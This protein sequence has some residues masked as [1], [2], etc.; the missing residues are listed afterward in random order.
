MHDILIGAP[1]DILASAR[2][3]LLQRSDEDFIQSTLDELRSPQGRQALAGRRAKAVNAQGTLKLFQPIQR[4]FHLALVEAWC[5]TPGA[6]RIDPQRV[7]SAGL[8]VRRLDAGG[9]PQGWMRSNGRVRGWV[10]ISRVG[11]SASDPA[12]RHRLQRRLTGVA[13]IDRQLSGFALRQPDNLFEE[14]VVPLFI[15][16]PDVCAE[17]GKTVFY[18]M[19]PT[20]SSEISEAAPAASAAGSVDFG[21]NSSAFRTHLAAPLRGLATPFPFAGAQVVPGWFDASEAPGEVRPADVSAAQFAALKAPIENS[22]Q[23]SQPAG[24]MRVFLLLL[25]QLASEFNAFDG[26]AEANALRTALAAIRLPLV[27]KQGQ[28]E[29]DTVRADLFLADACKLLLKKESI[30]APLEMPERWP[31]LSPELTQGLANAMHSAMQARAAALL[32]Q[33]CRYDE[34]GARYQ[35]RAFVRIK[36]EGAC[37]TRIVWSQE[38]EPFVIA[39]WYESADARP[40]VMIPLPDASDRGMLKQLKPNVAFVVP[41]SMQNLLSGKA[42]DLLEGK[43]DMGTL[44]I[45]WI[46]GFNIPIITI[47]AFIVLNIFLTLFNLIFGWLFF[48][49]ICVPFPKMGN[50]APAKPPYPS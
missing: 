37:P 38:S 3:V 2:P 28:S 43:A 36:P 30:A 22:E 7:D 17:A 13:D 24:R 46:C 29:P 31:A 48:I 45:T 1:R 47:C 19:V 11:G 23:P 10:P 39:P 42:K 9:Q 18:G 32:P 21:P 25:R 34:P 8:V 41:P 12:A 33:S 4:Q 20:V 49:K 14:D 15:A 5:D 50:K 35:V 27:L 40:P 44:G 26:G 6:P 16:P